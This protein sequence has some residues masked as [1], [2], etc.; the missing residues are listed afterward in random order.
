MLVDPLKAV[1]FPSSSTEDSRILRLVVPTG[2]IL[3][4]PKGFEQFNAF[5]EGIR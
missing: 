1:N 3:E 5:F 4:I 2:I